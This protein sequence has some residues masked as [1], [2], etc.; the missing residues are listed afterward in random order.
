MDPPSR[1]R[2]VPINGSTTGGFSSPTRDHERDNVKFFDDCTRISFALQ[3]SVPEAVRRTVRDNWEKC[4][5]GSDFHQAFV[6]RIFFFSPPPLP[7]PLGLCCVSSDL[8]MYF[9]SWAIALLLGSF[10]DPARSSC[11]LPIMLAVKAV[12]LGGSL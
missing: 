10:H 2:A 12:S 6:V 4:L 3:Q 5:L 7:P 1:H 8:D 11:L 9:P